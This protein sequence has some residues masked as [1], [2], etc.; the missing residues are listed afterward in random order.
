MK[1]NIL[2]TG[3]LLSFIYFISA[4][5]GIAE[6][7]RK[8]HSIADNESQSVVF[9]STE[10][11]VSRPQGFFDPFDFFFDRGRG[12]NQN[13]QQEFKQSALGSGVIY[14][15]KGNDYYIIT[16]NHVVEG[17][18]TVKVTVDGRKEYNAE[19]IGGD[20]N[21]DIA[22]LKVTTRDNLRLARI[23]DSST[24]RTADLVAA[25]G[26]PFGLSHSITFGIISA[27]GRS[28]LD[29]T[30]PGFTSFIQTDAAINPGNSGGPLLNIDGEVIG[31]NTMIYSQSGGNIGIGFA[32]PIN[33]ARGLSDQLIN[34]GKI[35]HG[36]IGITF[37]EMNKEK[38]E[39]LGVTS[40]EAG[41]LVLQV[42][43]DGPADKAGIQSGDII[44]RIDNTEMIRSSD[45]T[46][47]IGNTS[48]GTRLAVTFIRD[49]SI[50]M[51]YLTV[52]RRDENAAAGQGRRESS[53]QSGN[54][55]ERYGMS[56][57]EGRDGL[58]VGNIQQGSRAAQAGIRSGDV[59]FR[60]NNQNVRTL[61][62]FNNAVKDDNQ[63]A[64]FFIN[65]NGERVIVMM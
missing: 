17:A 64:Y 52:G 45:L 39:K 43:P 12:Q 65:R 25:I 15:K 54:V 36:W 11:T 1:R 10:K 18:D 20:K 8:L 60:I 6:L 47:L 30:K 5:T 16:N 57:T 32:I 58:T 24:L 37:Q 26:N 55:N 46:I 19:I 49:K 22:V 33:I 35:E 53:A 21:V 34:T 27:L 63:S 56:L 23:G 59:I 9:I 29:R 28:D 7:Q 4:E 41:M 31:I 48:P 14:H 51:K 62:D 40:T 13:R 61:N 38:L 3:L 50:I 44:T 2:I 42:V